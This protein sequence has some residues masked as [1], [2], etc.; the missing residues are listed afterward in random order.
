[1]NSTNCELS[2][3]EENEILCLYC[4]QYKYK[5]IEENKILC[6]YCKQ[7][8]YKIKVNRE[9]DEIKEL[10]FSVRMLLNNIEDMVKSRFK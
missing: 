3:R 7:Y 10:L 9:A 1:M 5:N 6:L 8:K 2:N 4:K